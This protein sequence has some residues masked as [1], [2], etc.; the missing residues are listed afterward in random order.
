MVVAIAAPWFVYMYLRFRDAFIAGYV[1]DE[2]IKLFATERFGGQPSF[3]FYFQLL[4][5]G[6]LP[7]TAIVAGRLVDDVRSAAARRTR[8]NVEVLLWAWTIGIVGFFTL[9]KFKLDH[10]L[11]PAAPALCLL[12]ARAWV[13]VRESP[14]APEHRWAR[15]GIRCVG[16]LLIVMGAVAAFFQLRRFDLPAVTLTAPALVVIGGLVMTAGLDTKGSRLTRT[17]WVALTS[18]GAI[19]VAIVLAVMP[20]LERQKVV[21]DI[22]RWVAAR[23]DPDTR[24]A[25]YQLNRWNT[26]FRFYVDRHVTMMDSG[27]QLHEFL[28]DPGNGK[29]FYLVMP[30]AGYDQL[31]ESGVALEE[32][33]A[34]EGLW[35]TSGRVL[36]REGIPPTRFVVTR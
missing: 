24:V 35:A 33:Y 8:D 23:A 9:S 7:W 34:R 14:D 1:L 15:I 3:W 10:Y 18:L 28:S 16:P 27:D 5:T 31:R 32:V 29:P 11:F 17:P 13:D 20:A 19:Y 22:A 36:W 4:A 21:P 2:N 25:T 26:A 30:Q 12:S 6:M